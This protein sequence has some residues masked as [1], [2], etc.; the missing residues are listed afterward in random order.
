MGR[1]LLPKTIRGKIMA[2]TASITILIA[3]V[4]VF[5]C[6]RVFQ[7]FLYKNQIQ[8]AEF[9]MNLVAS[10]AASDLTRVISFTNWCCTNTEIK[11]YLETF[12]YQDNLSILRD[13]RLKNIALNTYNRLYDEYNSTFPR[14]TT[15]ITRVIISTNNL[16]NYLQIFPSSSENSSDA[17]RIVSET[18]F[19]TPL[20]QD[21]HIRWPGIIGDPFTKVAPP[22]MIPIVRPIE[23]THNRNVL[24]WVYVTVSPQVFTNYLKSF[25]L[26]DDSI[27]YITIGEKI[28]VYQDSTLL[29]ADPEY[30]IINEIDGQVMNDDTLVQTIQTGIGKRRT[31]VTCRLDIPGISISQV[32]SEQQ[33]RSQTQVYLMLIAGICL[34][35]LTLGIILTFFMNR[36]ISLPVNSVRKKIALI[37]QGDFTPDPEIE[38]EHEIG[39]IGKGI[40]DLSKNVVNLMNK[41]IADEQQRKDLEYQILQSQINPHFLYNALN[42][43]KWMAAIQS[44]T[45]IVDMTTALARLLKNVSKGNTS[46]IPFKEELDLVKD[47]FLIQQ[48]RYGGSITIDYQIASEDLYE[49]RIHRFSLQPLIENSLFHGI[50]PK[51]TAGKVVVT[52]QALKTETG[53]DLQI[54]ITDNGVGM[55]KKMIGK[56]LNGDTDYKA[57]FFK[58]VGINNV[59]QRIR[60]DFGKAYGIAI[61]SEPGVYTTMTMTIPYLTEAPEKGGRL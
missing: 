14:S 48:Y 9:S 61:T 56:I 47:Y 51:G 1:K 25:P 15:P 39:D 18:D 41:R 45:G 21:H 53:K 7:S 42:S 59:N 52:A 40:N 16:D 20:Y 32:L 60:H 12:Q 33:A 13:Q 38:W 3:V 4:T 44:A 5:I 8:S 11:S 26:A 29:E 23:S 35:I 37:S 49:C 50:E 19:F 28:Y 24:G 30:L 46:L 2:V 27:L 36:I 55:S 43:I 31:M 22:Q 58:H 10:N 17:A 6:Y 54:T 57:D 34:I